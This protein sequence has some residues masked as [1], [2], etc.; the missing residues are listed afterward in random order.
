MIINDILFHLT[1]VL[2]IIIY[3]FV[4]KELNKIIDENE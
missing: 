1:P 3:P 2:I 4:N